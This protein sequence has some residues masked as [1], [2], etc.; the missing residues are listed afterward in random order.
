MT[1]TK[2][3][4]SSFLICT[5]LTS[6]PAQR[7]KLQTHQFDPRIS[8]HHPT[9]YISFVRV[10]KAEPVLNGESDERVWLRLNNNTQWAI[11][12]DANGVPDKL[13]GDVGLFYAVE[14]EKW[15]RLFGSTSCHVCSRI[16]LPP[17]K[18]MTFSVPR[19]DL[20]KNQRIHLIFNYDWEEHSE[21]SASEVEHS[22]FFYGRDVKGNA[23]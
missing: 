15:N 21:D 19:E 3:L 5:F 17:G 8:K 4:V 11:W 9:I 12:I 2:L 18:A 10:G 20:E 16:P 7:R 13:Y 23:R 22:L 14:D 6:A 1:T